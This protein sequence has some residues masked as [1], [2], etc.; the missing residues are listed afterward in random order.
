VFVQGSFWIVKSK[1]P[2]CPKKLWVVDKIPLKL[3]NSQILR[4]T[5]ENLQ[6]VANCSQ[7]LPR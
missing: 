3:K 5:L 4:K 6:I 1:L 7:T 2:W